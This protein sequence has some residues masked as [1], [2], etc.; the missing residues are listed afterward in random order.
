M[1]SLASATYADEG[2]AL[3][4]IGLMI[5]RKWSF[6]FLDLVVFALDEERN[7]FHVEFE[8]IALSFALFA[9]SSQEVG[10]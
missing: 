7:L 1:W 3:S 10:L 9:E 5:V 2:K 6:A 4:D 8:Y